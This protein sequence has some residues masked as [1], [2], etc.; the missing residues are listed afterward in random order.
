MRQAIEI[1]TDGLL[2]L[3]C[4]YYSRRY[5]KRVSA[6]IVSVQ[7][8]AV[9]KSLCRTSNRNHVDGGLDGI[10]AIPVVAS[11][12][13]RSVP[14]ASFDHNLMMPAFTRPIEHNIHFA[15]LPRTST[16]HPFNGQT[17]IFAS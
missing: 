7:F 17:I 14:T 10:P 6:C 5:F 11:F 3:R 9:N 15:M 16:I 1:E 8:S 4:T 2:A 12:S 13:A